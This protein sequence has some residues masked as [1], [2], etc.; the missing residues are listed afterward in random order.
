MTEYSVS[1]LYDI[2]RT[3]LLLKNKDLIRYIRVTNDDILTDYKTI[4]SKPHIPLNDILDKYESYGIVYM[5][6]RGIMADANISKY[7]ENTREITNLFL[8]DELEQN[9]N[10]KPSSSVYD[11][12]E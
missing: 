11:S 5:T 10:N 1:G 12:D 3:N 9:S 7:Q 6:I 4:K 2:I 8:N